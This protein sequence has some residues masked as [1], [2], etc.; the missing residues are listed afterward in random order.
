VFSFLVTVPLLGKHLSPYHALLFLRPL[1]A[2][3]MAA[4]VMG[5]FSRHVRSEGIRQACIALLTILALLAGTGGAKAKLEDRFWAEGR[6]P[7]PPRYLAL[8]E[9]FATEGGNPSDV[10][11]LSTNELSFAVHGFTGAKLVTGRRSHFFLFGKGENDFQEVWMDAAIVL[12][13]RDGERRQQVLD[14][15]TELAR[16][17]GKTLLLYWDPY[18]V[19]SEWAVNDGRVSPFDPFR[20]EYSPKREAMLNQNGIRYKTV[21]NAVFDPSVQNDP[22]IARLTL[23]YVTPDNYRSS[24]LPWSEDL[25]QYLEGVWRFDTGGEV[26]ARLFR[27]VAP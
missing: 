13:G 20:F 8:Q 24:R 27:I 25:D 6:M 7:H 17:T 12:Y 11:I 19:K 23:M 4:I 15:W 3:L 10:I 26:D 2:A 18:W 21:E 1:F 22:G 5:E 16:K 9:W 14:A